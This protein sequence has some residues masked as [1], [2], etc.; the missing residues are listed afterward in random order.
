[1]NKCVIVCG[2][3]PLILEEYKDELVI[4][5]D[6]GALYLAKN[7]IKMDFAIGDFDSVNEEEFLI[8]KTYTNNLIKLNPIKDDTDLEHALKFAKEKGYKSIDVYGCLGG[9]QDHNLLNL[10]LL[11]L[12]DLDITYY[13]EK[14]KIFSLKEGTYKIYKDNYKYLSLFTFEDCTLSLEGTYY[15]IKRTTLTIDDNY[16][17]SNEILEKYCQIKIE[18]G[19]L[20]VILCN[21]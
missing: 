20:L 19:R 3:K 2:Y 11:Y 17:T 5:V 6:K 9:R 12:S 8:I 14:H 10:K 16:T 4:G 13:D 18:K 15:P 21:D 1:M 7:N